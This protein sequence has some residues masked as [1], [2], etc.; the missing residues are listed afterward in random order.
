MLVT[1]AA[2][3]PPFRGHGRA[4]P[5]PI[6]SAVLLLCVRG[7][8][9]CQTSKGRFEVHVQRRRSLAVADAPRLRA[10]RNPVRDK[11]TDQRPIFPSDHPSNLSEQVHFRASLWPQIRASSTLSL[12]ELSSTKHTSDDSAVSRYC[13]RMAVTDEAIL[14]IK[15]MILTGRLGPGS[16]LPPEQ[17]LSVELGLSRNSLREA[18]KALEVIRILDVRRGDGTYV[19]S[20]EPRLLLEVMS[21]VV[22]LRADDSV[23][24]VTEVRRILEPA[25]AAMAAQ[26]LDGA[27]LDLLRKSLD[28]V[29]PETSVEALVEHDLE[30][31]SSIVKAS[32]NAYLASLVES[33]SGPTS[34]ARVWRGITEEGAIERTIS[35]H[36]GIYEALAAHDGQLASVL[37]FAHINGVEKWLRRA[38]GKAR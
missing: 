32:G 18:V 24:E 9:W 29:G 15:D 3:I 5:N 37:M 13:I 1:D 8:G 21:F 30:F 11:P 35:E 22:D 31:H 19:T 25:A 33:M 36:Q 23:I 10:P 2:Y 20:L 16:R 17:E 6:D 4:R 14:R 34:R 38:K 7:S 27:G 26:S 12:F 28:A